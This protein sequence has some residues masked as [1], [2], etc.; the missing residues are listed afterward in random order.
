MTFSI[1]ARDGDAF[2]VAVASKFLAAGA[3][4]PGVRTGVGAVATQS[5]ARVAYIPELLDALAGAT[6]APSAADAL[7][8]ATAADPDRGSRQVGVVG[9][10]DAATFTGADCVPW[11]GGRTGPGYAVQGNM[12]TGPEVVEEMERA[13]I[14]DADA[15]LARRLVTALLAGEAAGGDSRGRQS[16]AVYVAAPGLGYDHC[17]VVDLRVDDHPAAPSE[18]ARIHAE[19]ELYFGAPEDVVPLAGPLEAEVRER[20]RAL[21]FRDEPTSLALERWAGEVNLEMRLTPDGIDGR[22]LEFLRGA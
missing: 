3:I 6:S 5:F 12:L 8:A 17:G 16:A 10:S 7:A 2:G 15:P 4:V 9:A 19:W 13:F 21:G 18:L 11:A 1:V 22:V 14:A 20:L